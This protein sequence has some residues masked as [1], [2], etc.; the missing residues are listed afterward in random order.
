MDQEHEFLRQQHRLSHE[1]R[2]KAF[3]TIVNNLTL[4]E[5][6]TLLKLIVV[7]RIWQREKWDVLSLRCLRELLRRLK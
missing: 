2:V 3:A 6:V 4:S 7:D 1:E 5:R